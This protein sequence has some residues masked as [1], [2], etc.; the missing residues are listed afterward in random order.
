MSAV[1]KFGSKQYLVEVNQ[2]IAV[3]YLKDCKEGDLIDV[4]VLHTFGGTP[5]N[6]KAKVLASEKA[7]K[8]RVVKFKSKSRYFRR[9]GHRTINTALQIVSA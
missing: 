2:K 9:Y 6:L 5:S 8:I 3:D 4:S 7:K 1:I